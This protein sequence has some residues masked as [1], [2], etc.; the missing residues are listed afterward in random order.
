[1]NDKLSLPVLVL[2]DIVLFPGTT[3][4][5]FIGRKQSIEALNAAKHL[6]SGEYILLTAQKKPELDEPK[7]TDLYKIGVLGKIIQTVKLPNNSYKVLAEIEQRAKLS[8]HPESKYPIADYTML[9]DGIIDDLDELELLVSDIL[10]KF[11]EY[12]KINRKINPDI[13]TS[14]ADQRNPTYVTNIVAS[15]LTCSVASKQEL[16]EI[17]DVQKRA[18]RLLTVLDT[19]IALIET[20][21]NLQVQVKKQIEKTQRDYFLNE[22]MKVIQKELHG[23]DEKT[24]LLDFENKIKTLKLSKDAK[25]KAESELRKLK[26][27]NPMSSESSVVRNYLETLL[28]MPW[29]KEDKTKIDIT[30]AAAVL[31]KDHYGLE[32]V[33]DRIIEYLAVLQRAKTLQSPILCF[34]GPPGVGKTSLVKSIADAVGRKYAKIALGGVHDESEIR[35][36]RKTYLGSMPGKIISSIKKVKTNNPVILLDEIDKMS[37][38]FRGDPASALLEVLDPEQNKFFSD[39][40]LDVE[41]DLSKVMFIATANSYNLPRPLLDRLEIINISGYI[42]DEKLQIA[43][44]HLVPKQLQI[45]TVKKDELVIPEDTLLHMIRHYTK[46]SGVRNLEREIGTLTR[47]ALKKLLTDKKIKSITIKPKDLEEY[48]G[49]E[50]YKYGQA[51]EKDQIGSCTGLAYTEVGGELLTIEAIT[52]PG[53]GKIKATGKLGDVMKES[54]DAAFSVVQSRASNLGIDVKELK[55]IDIH[56]HVPE[57]A[58]P[59]DGPS[60][61][62]AIFTTVTSLL[63]KIPVRRDIAMTGEITLRGNVLPIGGLKEKLLAASRGGIKTVII[64]KENERNLKDIPKSILSLLKI[65]PIA[66]VDELLDI[67]FVSRPGGKGKDKK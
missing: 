58:T 13:L 12:V 17:V 56:L 9:P 10:F 26:S 21:Q 60:A 1:M 18:E 53:A 55:K 67:A 34:V 37:H 29:G 59:K 32:K 24:E 45:H 41:Y 19:E 43:I 22:Q 11:N 3:A 36:H 44:K 61:G 50:K 51:E 62:I 6:G 49:V 39:H 33:K 8:F 7:Y 20:E 27:M 15:H 23:H 66:T 2:R 46:E 16:M 30:K 42:E 5:L 28:S 52:I 31:D 40:Y 64:P 14:I 4:P 35:G 63:S 54:A 38:D 47:K 48:L 25:E 57:G 65:I